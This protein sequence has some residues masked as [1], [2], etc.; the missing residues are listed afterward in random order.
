MAVKVTCSKCKKGATIGQ[1]E[2]DGPT[3]WKC[4]HCEHTN[5]E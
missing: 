5:H 4:P 2:K 1:K 3:I